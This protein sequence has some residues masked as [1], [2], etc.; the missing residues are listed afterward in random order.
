MTLTDAARIVARSRIAGG[1]T[2]GTITFPFRKLT[3]THPKALLC[4]RDDGRAP[5]G[6]S[7]LATGAPTNATVDG[8][9]QQVLVT[10]QFYRPGTS[11]WWSLLPTI[12]HRAGVLK[13]SLSG[14]WSFW[15]AAALVFVAGAGA[16]AISLVGLRR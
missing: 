10:V 9:P 8:T 16:L 5:L 14:D 1:W 2:G 13:G 11:N 7:G 6:F 15:L 12:A 4:I 3:R